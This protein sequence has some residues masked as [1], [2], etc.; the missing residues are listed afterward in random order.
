MR[1]IVL[2]ATVVAIN[3]IILIGTGVGLVGAIAYDGKLDAPAQQSP[4]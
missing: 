1:V 4:W 2:I 3:I